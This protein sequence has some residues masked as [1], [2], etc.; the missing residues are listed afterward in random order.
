M[1]QGDLIRIW[2]KSTGVLDDMIGEGGREQDDLD[3]LWQ[4]PRARIRKPSPIFEAF[5]LLLDTN[6]LISKAGLVQHVVG[7]VEDK[8]F[9]LV[10]H[11]LAAFDH[12]HGSSRGADNNLSLE[13]ISIAVC[14]LR[15][16]SNSTLQTLD[17][18][19]HDLDDSEDLTGQLA[20]WRKYKSLR[21]VD[22][23]VRIVK[24][25]QNVKNKC[26]CL[27]SARLRLSNHV[28]GRITKQEGKS[29]LLNLRRLG[30]THVINAFEN[31]FIP[32]ERI[33]AWV[34]FFLARDKLTSQALR[35]I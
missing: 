33:R 27:S 24:T 9:N 18:V 25:R 28:D 16:D 17:E 22:H 13:P 26:C 31:V 4:E 12:V 35:R 11:Q 14:D 32:D 2:S 15:G 23:R 29:F 5:Y 10:S 34:I 20:A 8:D 19:S 7:L 6:A 3:I 21:G 30:E 1:S